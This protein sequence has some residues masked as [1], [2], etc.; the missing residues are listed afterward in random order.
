MV[1]PK[2]KPLKVSRAKDPTNKA[3][4]IVLMP[5]PHRT[6]RYYPTGEG[7]FAGSEAIIM[8]GY[9]GCM[10]MDFNN[11][12]VRQSWFNIPELAGHCCIAGH[13]KQPAIYLALQD[14]N[15][16]F[17]IAHADGYVSLLPQVATVTAAHLTGIPVVLTQQSR[18][19]VGDTKFLHLFGLQPDGRLDGKDEKLAMP[20][21]LVKGIAY[22]EKHARLYV[23]VDKAD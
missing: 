12:N 14:N 2:A 21:A 15:R 5:K 1:Q 23:A 10:I 22:S 16:L 20:C 9:S 19:A 7:W 4:R 8:G 11:G 6:H 3:T 13:P 17:Q 18:L